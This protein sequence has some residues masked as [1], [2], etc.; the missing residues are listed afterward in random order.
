MGI[1][2]DMAF[3]YLNKPFITRLLA[4][5]RKISRKSDV[6]FLKNTKS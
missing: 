2:L 3:W 6:A 5:I 4:I 1:P